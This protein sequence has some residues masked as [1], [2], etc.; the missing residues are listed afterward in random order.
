M[1]CL[2]TFVR[3]L[4]VKPDPAVQFEKNPTCEPG[5]Q[6]MP[7]KN[8]NR[9]CDWQTHRGW[10]CNGSCCVTLGSLAPMPVWFRSDLQGHT[11]DWP[12][13]THMPVCMLGLQRLACLHE[14]WWILTPSHT[15]SSLSDGAWRSG[16]AGPGC[17]RG[18]TPS[19]W[20]RRSYQSGLKTALDHSHTGQD[21][22]VSSP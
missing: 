9:E 19:C 7:I 8:A 4:D 3:F 6:R 12:N 15:I 5:Q 10:R 20:R 1:E 22:A 18:A 11:S 17:V 16:T 2:E 14:C 21:T 13:C